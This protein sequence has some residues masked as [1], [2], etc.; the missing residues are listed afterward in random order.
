MSSVPATPRRQALIDRQAH[1][2]YPVA[3]PIPEKSPSIRSAQRLQRT[4]TQRPTFIHKQSHPPL[5]TP[6]SSILHVA[7]IAATAPARVPLPK[8]PRDDQG[9][10]DDGC[11][12]LQP[13]RT[14]LSRPV[15]RTGIVNAVLAPPQ[16]R[17]RPQAHSHEQP[18]R[19]AKKAKLEERVEERLRQEERFKDKYTR[20]FPSFKFYFDSLDAS[21]KHSFSNRVQQL[22]AVSTHFPQPLS[23][24]SLTSFIANRGFLLSVSYTLHYQQ[25]SPICRGRCRP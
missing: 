22:G 17:P 10:D 23:L 25:N 15:N 1:T 12:H 2:L 19:L 6:T 20:A 11:G 3:L 5:K 9:D 16:K 7:D 4:L 14:D 21:A 8:R 24:L 18:E 13:P